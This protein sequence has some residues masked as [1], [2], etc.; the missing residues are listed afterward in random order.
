MI[1]DADVEFYREHG[2]LMV[3]NV[4]SAAQL[5]ALREEKDAQIDELRTRLD[6]LEATL[7]QN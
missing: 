5:N 7:L 2:Y 4:L 1:S 6:R 3:P